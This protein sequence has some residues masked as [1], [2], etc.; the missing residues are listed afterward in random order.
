MPLL[1]VK[2]L[3][4]PVLLATCS[5]V[6]WKGSRALGGWLLGLP[7][8][9]GPVSILLM[10]ERGTYFAERAARGT[11]LGLLAAGAFCVWYA[12]LARRATWWV[13]L[14]LALA[15]CLATAWALSFIRLPV[16]WLAA[17]VAA[18]LGLLSLVPARVRGSGEQAARPRLGSLLAKMT[19]GS[20]IVVAVTGL[21]GALG[22]QLAGV[23][24]PLPVLLS[25]MTAGVH[26]RAGDE[27]ARSLLHGALAGMWGGV[28]FFAVVA[29]A[30]GALS[31][32]LAYGLAITLS[33]AG[34]A[35]A[36]WVQR[37][38]PRV[39]RPVACSMLRPFVTLIR[40]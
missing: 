7:I 29:L 40:G 24:A 26:R 39:S 15:A 38:T 6:A 2:A 19:G 11:L 12:A 25:F 13:T 22:P 14:S 35:L 17:F 23:L 8:V 31:P 28:A 36:M 21:A 16:V 30:I 10:V 3:I 37:H 4:A 5:L 27:A 32:F 1:L 33:L 9:S 34:S 18:G 20:A